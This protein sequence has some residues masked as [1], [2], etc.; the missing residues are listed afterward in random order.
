PPSVESSLS[1]EEARALASAWA[2]LLS[3]APEQP[4]GPPSEEGLAALRTFKAKKQ[5]FLAGL[6][7][8]AHRRHVKKL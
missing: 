7:S 1:E 6:P 2:A 5:A 3:E 8:E 4:A